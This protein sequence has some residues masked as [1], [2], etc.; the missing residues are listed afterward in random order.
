[1]PPKIPPPTFSDGDPATHPATTATLFPTDE[2]LYLKKLGPALAELYAQEPDCRPPGTPPDVL[3]EKS[4]E[5][6]SLPTGYALYKE[7]RAGGSTKAADSYLYGHPR[8]R[9]V[10][11]FIPHLIWL[12]RGGRL[13]CECQYCTRKKSSPGRSMSKTPGSKLSSPS[14]STT[15]RKGAAVSRLSGTPL[16]GRSSPA[17]SLPGASSSQAGARS[18]PP[19]LKRQVEHAPRYAPTKAP[20]PKGV[21]LLS[22]LPSDL[23]ITELDDD[24][25]LDVVGLGDGLLLQELDDVVEAEVQGGA[26]GAPA[27]P[28]DDPHRSTFLSLGA[29][30]SAAAIPPTNPIPITSTKPADSIPVTSTKPAE[31]AV[32]TTGILPA[33]FPTHDPFALQTGPSPLLV[34][35]APTPAPAPAPAPIRIP[36]PVES[37]AVNKNPPP[38]DVLAIATISDIPA[39]S[40]SNPVATKTTH[41][42]PPTKPR[43][44]ASVA[45]MKSSSSN[46]TTKRATPKVGP[47]ATATVAHPASGSSLKRPAEPTVRSEYIPK[48]RKPAAANPLHR[49]GEVVWVQIIISETRKMIMFVPAKIR[50]TL[51]EKNIVRTYQP[52]LWLEVNVSTE[53]LDVSP[54]QVFQIFRRDTGDAP[55]VAYTIELLAIPLKFD[56]LESSLVPFAV[57]APGVVSAAV[58]G[59]PAQFEAIPAAFAEAQRLAEER[60]A[61]RGTATFVGETRPQAYRWGEVMVGAEVLRIGDELRLRG[62]IDRMVL[63]DVVWDPWGPAGRPLGASPVPPPMSADCLELWVA[64]SGKSSSGAH[65]VRVSQVLGRLRRGPWGPEKVQVGPGPHVLPV[66]DGTLSL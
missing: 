10:N 59:L 41:A 63:Y 35:A 34:T 66:L 21:G 25:D 53:A 62:I 17:P 49:V 52:P 48:K 6:V 8:F 4:I 43:A 60:V 51:L 14:I 55:F 27:P 65:A 50:A 32:S 33:V 40:Q 23:Q 19:V 26:A 3:D 64:P 20:P 29:S 22:Q 46:G 36:I 47:A 24:E 12:A 56:V 13:E 7:V 2:K 16:S 61:V 30:S 11:E 5:L 38:A 28:A 58:A 31:P 9:S 1:M 18:A 54:T 37:S 15:K 39:A 57:Q 44:F 45:T 42:P